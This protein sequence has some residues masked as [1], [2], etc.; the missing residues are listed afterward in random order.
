[1]ESALF[2]VRRKRLLRSAIVV[3]AVLVAVFAG[4]E[5]VQVVRAAFDPP[6]AVL[7]YDPLLRW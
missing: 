2:Q 1:M 3:V 4:L 5:C 6:A 7:P